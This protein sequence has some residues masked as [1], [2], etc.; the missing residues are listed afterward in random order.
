[1]DGAAG[2]SVSLTA[3]SG[4]ATGSKDDYA[5]V[6]VLGAGPAAISESSVGPSFFQA[7]HSRAIVM[8]NTTTEPGKIPDVFR[9]FATRDD[10]SLIIGLL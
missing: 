5:S 2:S 1:M 10:L 6:S 3:T 9:W 4:E 8:C 7:I